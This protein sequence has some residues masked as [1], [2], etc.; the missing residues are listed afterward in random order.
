MPQPF[1]Y[2]LS[3]LATEEFLANLFLRSLFLARLSLQEKN[4]LDKVPELDQC[5]L[6]LT[7][8]LKDEAT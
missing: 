3:N 2:R 8:R 7:L 6:Q 4:Q 1:S 5:E